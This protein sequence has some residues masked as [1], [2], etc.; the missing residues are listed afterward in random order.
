MRKEDP[1]EEII[2]MD[3][4]FSAED[5]ERYTARYSVQKYKKPGMKPKIYF[6]YCKKPE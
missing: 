1:I 3:A 5:G 6:M 4:D 2:E